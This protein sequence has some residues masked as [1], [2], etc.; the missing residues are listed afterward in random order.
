[1]DRRT[2][3]HSPYTEQQIWA[4]I[5]QLCLALKAVYTA[6]GSLQTSANKLTE[7]SHG[8]LKPTNILLADSGLLSLTDYGLTHQAITEETI[9][10]TIDAVPE[11][12]L[13][14]DISNTQ[15]GMFGA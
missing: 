3:H 2:I 10:D 11:A 7:I 6:L 8:N 14:N 4:I 1:M 12:V 15:R 9:M 13:T 5:G